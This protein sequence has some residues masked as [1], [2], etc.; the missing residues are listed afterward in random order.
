MKSQPP[1][2]V[3]LVGVSRTAISGKAVLAGDFHAPVRIGVDGR[4]LGLRPKGI[5]RYIWELC[6]GLDNILPAARFFLYTPR[7]LNMPAISPRWSLRADQ[8]PL[9]RLSSN[10]WLVAGVGRLARC[11]DLDAFWAGSGLSPLIGLK[12]RTV[13]TV[14]DLVHKVA[15]QT[16]DRRALWAARLFFRSSLGNADAVV[17]NSEGTARRL[18]HLGYKVA[19]VVRP[20]LSIVFQPKSEYEVQQALTRYSLVRPYLLAVATWEPRKGLEPLIRAFLNMK[21][22]GLVRNHKLVL[23]GERG[24]KDVAIMNL[25]RRDTE[26]V[27]SLGF[28]DDVSLGALY[29]GADAFIFP[30]KYEGFGMPVL[31]ARACGALVVTSDIPELRE[32]GGDQAIYIEPTE[33]GIRNGISL[34]LKRRPT[35]RVD[36]RDWNWNKSAAILA[37]VL[38]GHLYGEFAWP[39]EVRGPTLA[40][41]SAR[42]SALS[43]RGL[44]WN[45]GRTEG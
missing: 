16:M 22:D 40:D 1:G 8:S 23:I 43:V 24:W 42:L 9:G 27:L 32:A 18:E 20:G 17:S 19:A 29:Q 26:S 13:L 34:A 7:P 33:E 4:R 25:A 37:E 38:L 21:A 31:E 12:T 35:E 6:K 39:A 14:H 45:S 10:L 30:S 15:P 41:N 28:V 3:R 44:P 36:W 11:D 5:G 2:A